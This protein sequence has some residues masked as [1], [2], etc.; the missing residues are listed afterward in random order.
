MRQGGVM[1]DDMDGKHGVQSLEIGMGI[2]GAMVNGQRAMMLRIPIP[3]IANPMA[4]ITRN[5]QNTIPTGG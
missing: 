1:S 5:A 4:T 3:S 2:L